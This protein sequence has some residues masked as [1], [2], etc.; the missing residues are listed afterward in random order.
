MSRYART[1]FVYRYLKKT[2]KL[3]PEAKSRAENLLLQ[4]Y[5][6]LMKFKK[7]D[8]GFHVLDAVSLLSSSLL[9]FLD[10]NFS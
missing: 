6:K 10:L 3:T 9:V 2:K 1:F 5:Q 7:K 8:G 4:G